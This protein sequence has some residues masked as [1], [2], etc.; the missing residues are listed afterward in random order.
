MLIILGR[1]NAYNVQKVLWTVGEIGM[2]YEHIDIG[3]VRGQ[4]DTA[5]FLALNPHGRIPVLLDDESTIWESNTIIRYLSATYATGSLWSEKP[6]ERSL[7]DRWMDWELATLQ[8]DFL[9]L[10]WCFFRTPA[11]LRNSDAIQQSLDRCENH[12]QKLDIHLGKQPY[13]AG[14][15][16][17]MGDIPCATSLYRYFEMGLPVSKPPNIV[18]WYDRLAKRPAYREH[19][20][21]SFEDLRGRQEY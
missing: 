21:L 7:A 15:T 16:F 9:A 18:A 5:E 19:I 6:I 14:E 13:L 11:K 12:F 4:L 2:P 1:R 10:F 17:T 3:S 8:P 20:M